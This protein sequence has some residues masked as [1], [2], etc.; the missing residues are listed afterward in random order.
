MESRSRPLD[1]GL[2]QLTAALSGALCE[3]GHTLD[4]S[5]GQITQTLQQRGEDDITLV[6]ARI[7]DSESGPADLG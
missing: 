7:L 1:D 2:A 4:G 6:L 5:C 3:P